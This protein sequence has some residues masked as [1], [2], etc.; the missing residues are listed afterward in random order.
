M[1]TKLIFPTK[2]DYSYENSFKLNLHGKS[3]SVAKALLDLPESM[4]TSGVA[5]FTLLSFDI[6]KI[7]LLLITRPD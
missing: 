7:L 3:P 5:I 6:L 4:V 1:S 2:I